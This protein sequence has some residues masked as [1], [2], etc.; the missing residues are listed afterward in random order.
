MDSL[1]TFFS[2]GLLIPFFGWGIYVLRVQYRYHHELSMTTEF[3]SLGA[4]AVIIALEVLLLRSWMRDND[5]QFIFSILGLFVSVAALYGPMMVSLFS[6]LFVEMVMPAHKDAI[7]TPDFGPAEAL[8][9]LGD[10]EG[11]VKE[12]MI[13]AR[14]FPKDPAAALRIADNLTKLER[15][16]E[17]TQWF[18]RSLVHQEDP[19]RN[20]R[21]TNRLVEIYTRRLDRVQEAQRVLM[22][23]L[24]RFPESERADNVRR[25]LEGL[26]PTQEAVRAAS[27]RAENLAPPEDLR[28]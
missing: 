28:G 27:P 19:D 17:S 15:F 22:E 7:S 9:R 5:L 14:I 1:A 2:I 25:R 6:H 13:I 21:A 24:E 18:E 23:Y 16:D 20:L 12:C 10:Y 26:S 3:L 4:V 8:E 11:A